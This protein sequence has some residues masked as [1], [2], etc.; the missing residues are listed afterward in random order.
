MTASRHHRLSVRLSDQE[1][2]VLQR[3]AAEVGESP[4]AFIRCLL[5]IPVSVIDNQAIDAG[6]N[7][8]AIRIV[9]FDKYT[10]TRLEKQLK[11]WGYH[12]NQAVHALNI[13]ASKKFM[14]EEDTVNIISKAM[15]FL[16]DIDVYR[17]EI[18]ETIEGLAITPHA[19]IGR[20]ALR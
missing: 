20:T 2:L 1:M 11:A 13:I 8:N 9:L 10:Y 16:E 5:A 6:V 12:Y 15:G 17:K 4:S 19:P 18:D 14:T 7:E 3:N